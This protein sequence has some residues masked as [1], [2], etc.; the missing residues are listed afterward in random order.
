MG[1]SRSKKTIDRVRPV[2]DL[3][4]ENEA[5][6]LFPSNNPT[7][8]SY[9]IRDA[10]AVVRGLP[11]D[12][13]DRKKYINIPQKFRIRILREGVQFEK[14]EEIHYDNPVDA[15]VASRVRVFELPDVV[16]M[17]GVVGAILK[18]KGQRYTFPNVLV[19]PDDTLRLNRWCDANSYVIES[20]L[21]LIIVRNVEDNETNH[22]QPVESEHGSSREDV[23]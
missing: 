10:L 21:P 6:L 12:S 5:G 20:T 23:R 16:N 18:H 9:A 8:L 22:A 7:K 15:L 14:R 19:T 2:L 3:L 11:P 13:E 1:Y 17:L 4:S